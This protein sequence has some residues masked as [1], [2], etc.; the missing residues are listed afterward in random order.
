MAKVWIKVC[1][2]KFSI[3]LVGLQLTL[4]VKYLGIGNIPAK[5]FPPVPKKYP[6]LS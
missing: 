2:M 3:F 6:L 1:N 4:L 5:V